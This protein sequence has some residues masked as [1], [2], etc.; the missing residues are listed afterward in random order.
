MDNLLGPNGETITY[1]RTGSLPFGDTI[2]DAYEIRGLGKPITLYL[3]EYNYTEP[4]A[5]AGLTCAAAFS[6]TPP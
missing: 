2:L 5:P 6:L 1:E 3:D 4:Q